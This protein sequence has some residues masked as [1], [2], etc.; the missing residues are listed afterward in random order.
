MRSYKQSPVLRLSR[1]PDA[2]LTFVIHGISSR[3]IYSIQTRSDWSLSCDPPTTPFPV[4]RIDRSTVLSFIRFLLFF[5]SAFLLRL[6]TGFSSQLASP[7]NSCSRFRKSS[8]ALWSRL[9]WLVEPLGLHLARGRLASLPAL[10][11][12]FRLGAFGRSFLLGPL[13]ILCPCRLP[14][15]LGALIS[16][17]LPVPHTDRLCLSPTRQLPLTHHSVW[18]AV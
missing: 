1:M 17:R 6:I 14:S 13:R 15:L 7:P 9:N 3:S 12:A 11:T 10:P 5:P 8:G 2:Y 4:S 18:R 16:L